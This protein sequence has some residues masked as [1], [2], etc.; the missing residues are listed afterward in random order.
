MRITV[1]VVPI[2]NFDAQT[3]RYEIYIGEIKHRKEGGRD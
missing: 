1:C 3:G 2:C